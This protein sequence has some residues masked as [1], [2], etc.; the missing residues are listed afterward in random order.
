MWGGGSLQPLKGAKL[1]QN[2]VKYLKYWKSISNQLFKVYVLIISVRFVK[3][4]Y[5]YWNWR[6]RTLVCMADRGEASHRPVTTAWLV[7]VLGFLYDGPVMAEWSHN[8][9][10]VTR[11][12]ISRI[13]AYHE[14][15]PRNGFTNWQSDLIVWTSTGWIFAYFE[16]FLDPR[17][18][19]YAAFTVY[20]KSN[21]PVRL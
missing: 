17:F 2:R 8:K 4:S 15:S 11:L 7:A 14:R 20:Y 5:L 21:R 13:V 19:S 6:K 16:F 12:R 1:F 10:R 18:W 9:L 3:F